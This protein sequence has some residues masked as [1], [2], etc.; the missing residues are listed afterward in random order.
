MTNVG[1]SKE[2]GCK[3]PVPKEAGSK[4]AAGKTLLRR[5]LL[6]PKFCTRRLS[7]GILS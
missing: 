4:E 3:E 5:R 1:T 7:V 6:V 2:A